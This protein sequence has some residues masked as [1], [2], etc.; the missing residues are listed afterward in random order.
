MKPPSCSCT[1]SMVVIACAL[2]LF[3]ACG[4]SGSESGTGGSG[5]SGA[6]LSGV[7]ASVE[8]EALTI[9]F[10]AGGVVRMSMKDV[11]DSQGTYTIDGEKII[12]AIDGQQHTFIRDGDCIEEA[13]HI[14]GKLCKGGKTGA[15]ANVSTRSIPNPPTG[16]WVATNED[17]EFRIEFRPGNTL[18]MTLTPSTGA[19]KPA[20]G[21]FEIE[22]DTLYATLDDGTP[23]VLKY[24]NNA[25]ESSAFGLPMKFQKK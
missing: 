19:A 22:G 25:F 6:G 4:K 10:K 18:T 15:A 8:N 9:E 14:F 23:M 2:S 1:F 11:G 7:F 3:Q 20:N 24:V 13:R 17:G 21:K 16:T 12:V 5:N